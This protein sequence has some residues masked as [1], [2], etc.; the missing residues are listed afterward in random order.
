MQSTPDQQQPVL[1]IPFAAAAG[2]DGAAPPPEIY[3]STDHDRY[4]VIA[5]PND[6]KQVVLLSQRAVRAARNEGRPPAGVVLTDEDKATGLI[7]TGGQ[8]FF[9]RD[10]TPAGKVGSIA[11]VAAGADSPARNEFWGLTSTASKRE[12]R[13]R[14]SSGAREKVRERDPQAVTQDDEGLVRELLYHPDR[15]AYSILTDRDKT[16][17][18]WPGD[19]QTWAQKGICE[20]M[21]AEYEPAGTFRSRGQGIRAMRQNLRTLQTK[22]T[23]LYERNKAAGR[24]LHYQDISNPDRFGNEYDDYLHFGVRSNP[25]KGTPR[26]PAAMRVYVN[27]KLWAGGEVAA[28]VVRTARTPTYNPYG[29]V[30]D[31]STKDQD[32]SLRKDKLLFVCDTPEQLDAILG[33]LRTTWRQDP[34]LFETAV[35]P[36]VETTD[37][38]GVGLAEEPVRGDIK[39]SFNGRASTFL[40]KSW[41]VALDNIPGTSI[42]AKDRIGTWEYYKRAELTRALVRSGTLPMPRLVAEFRKAMRRTAPRFGISPHNVAR[43]LR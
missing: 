19:S 35:L 4:A 13:P 22:R 32:I 18:N 3:F 23:D 10:R 42:P 41:L 8:L 40:S 15:E 26:L 33:A 36:M 14:T 20:L 31:Q 11:V 28:R 2:R 38:P 1:N 30:H 25:A 12:A 27:T 39:E 21:D 37:I 29:K 7:Q 5:Y 24:T 6:P 43:N 9:G 16:L 34:G 17:P